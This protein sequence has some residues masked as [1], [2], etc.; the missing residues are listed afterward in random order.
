MVLILI[1]RLLNTKVS[2]AMQCAMV[3]RRGDGTR[4]VIMSIGQINILTLHDFM[5]NG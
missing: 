3:D 4:K 1:D 2:L 5:R